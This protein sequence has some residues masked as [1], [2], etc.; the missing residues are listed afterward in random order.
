MAAKV[1]VKTSDS[2]STKDLTFLPAINFSFVESV[3]K[4]GSK[5]QGDK[6]ISKG[7]KYFSEK[8]LFNISV[9]KLDN[10]C[11]VTARCHRS[12]K[13]NESPHEIE[14]SLVEGPG[15]ES[16]NCSCAIGKSGT[17]GLV[18]GLLYTLAHM[19][20]SN[21]KSI[22]SDI[23]KTSLPQTWHIPRGKPRG[24]R[25]TLYNPSKIDFPPVRELC[26]AVSKVDNSILMLSV[27]S[28]TSQ[29][30][31]DTKFGKFPKGSALGYQQKLSAHYILNILDEDFPILPIDNFMLNTL[32]VA[33]NR[34]KT[35]SFNAIQVSMDET[36]NIEVMT[37]LQSDDPRWHAVRRDR[38]TASVA[39]DIVKRRAGLLSTK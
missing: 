8:Y 13:K 2:T 27:C 25:S 24:L 12:Q 31:T 28:G 26:E 10:G 16:S 18:T 21:L 17:C 32:Q 39:G 19:K 14:I 34:T 20:A 6:E 38:L 15:L 33:L 3:V 37:R 4:S 1:N 29:E 35:T 5:S 36:R 30:T 23:L 22:P 7:Y 11:M 9:H